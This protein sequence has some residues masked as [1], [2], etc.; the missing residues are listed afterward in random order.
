MGAFLPLPCDYD[1]DVCV[2]KSETEIAAKIN[3][4][5]DESALV[6]WDLPEEM[7]YWKPTEL[8]LTQDYSAW[9]RTYDRDQRPNYMYMAGHQWDDVIANGW[10]CR[11]GSLV[12]NSS[13]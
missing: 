10:L 4:V 1:G 6:W 13:F 8:Q 7:A 2:G 11:C 3:A 12:F 9:T 5:E